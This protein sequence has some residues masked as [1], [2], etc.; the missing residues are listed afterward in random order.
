M[1]GK[2]FFAHF[3]DFACQ[4]G[5]V[6]FGG[7]D[8]GADAVEGRLNFGCAADEAGAG[9]GLVF[10]CPCVFALVFSE[11]GDAVGEETSVAVG[12]QAQ[13]GLVEAGGARGAG[14]AADVRL[15]KLTL[16]NG[17]HEPDRVT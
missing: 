1:G 3:D 17:G 8:F 7:E 6:A 16:F 15:Q 13:V 2:H 9:E 5:L 4:G 14:A 12:A 11:G 10:P